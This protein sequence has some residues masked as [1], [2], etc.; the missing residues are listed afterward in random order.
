MIGIL[1]YNLNIQNIIYFA[2]KLYLD[3]IFIKTLRD[4]NEI[5]QLLQNVKLDKL[6]NSSI[7][8]Q[9]YK[10]KYEAIIINRYF[11]NENV[12]QKIDLYLN[13][14]KDTIP[15]LNGKEI[16][17]LGAKPGPII[18]EIMDY[19]LHEKLDGNI[20]NKDQAKIKATQILNK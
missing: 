11:S 10:Y 14:L 19:L 1:I 8:K 13:K 4:T 17:A 3:S 16:I 2:E 18:K 9:L 20:K 12:C 15:P 6:K 5:K 7:Y